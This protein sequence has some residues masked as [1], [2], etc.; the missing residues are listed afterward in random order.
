MPRAQKPPRALAGG[1][2]P[3]LRV[4]LIAELGAREEFVAPDQ[5]GMASPTEGQGVPLL[6]PVWVLCSD[7]RGAAI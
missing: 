1:S 2:A 3:L 7:G 5:P 6:G 4:R